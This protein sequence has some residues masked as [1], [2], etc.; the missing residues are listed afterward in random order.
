L[1]ETPEHCHKLHLPSPILTDAELAKIRDLDSGEFKTK[2]ISLL[3]DLRQIDDFMAAVERVCRESRQAISDGYTFIVLSDRGVDKDH[4]ALPALLAT[5]AVHQH[6]V[7]DGCLDPRERRA[8][9]GASF[10]GAVRIRRRL[11]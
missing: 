11:R 9:R 4:M 2:M 7:K 6:L 3:F 1:E 10:R 8:A 5:G